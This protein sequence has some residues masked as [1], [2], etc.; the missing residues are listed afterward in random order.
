M[1]VQNV[2]EWLWIINCFG[3][4]N[5]RIWEFMSNF[6]DI[7]EAYDTM[8]DPEKRRRFLTEFENSSAGRV[9]EEQVTELISYC[10]KHN[11]YILTFDD[12][13][14]PERLKSIFDPPVVL[15]CRGN[16]DLLKNDFS[17]SVVGTRDPSNYSVKVTEALVRS[18]SEM[19][20]TIVSGF[21]VGID[22]TAHLASVRSGGKTIAVLGCGIDNN[23]PR[24]NSKYRK[25]IEANG[26][27]ISEYFPSASGSTRTFPVRNRILTGLSLGTIVIEAGLKSGA[28]NSASLAMSQ[29]RD[30]FVA[31]PHNLF[32]T[33]YGGNV[34]LIRDGAT[35]LCGV[36]DI[37]YEY[38]ENYGHKIANTAAKINVT[39]EEDNIPQKNV[40]K[41]KSVTVKKLV[42]DDIAEPKKEAYDPS[43]LEGEEL[44]IYRFLKE[45]GKAVL[46]DEI[47]SN[48][49]MDISEMLSLLTELEIA[50]AVSSS[51]G[52]SYEAN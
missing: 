47:A 5:K 13:K 25:E 30:V 23:Y 48:F 43:E 16:V 10:N 45:S 22:I 8:L 9:T 42:N 26:L 39:P 46:I 12:E 18:L 41:K 27:F 44:E 7:S 50:G 14:Y 19:D 40:T 29:G 49:D 38:Y 52:Q 3:C 36:N 31:A 11:I 4:A 33:R 1:D 15:F 2:F 24:E 28:L 34:S 17:L 32:D 37:I 51:A 35:C 21:A 6:S 20:I